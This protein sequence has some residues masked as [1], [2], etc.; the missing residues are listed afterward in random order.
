MQSDTEPSHTPFTTE[1]YLEHL[2]LRTDH[3]LP[4]LSAWDHLP[5]PQPTNPRRQTNSPLFRIAAKDPPRASALCTYITVYVKPSA[6][7]PP[8]PRMCLDCVSPPGELARPPASLQRVPPSSS[9]P[10]LSTPQQHPPPPL[11]AILADAS[12]SVFLVE[13]G[14]L[15]RPWGPRWPQVTARR[16]HLCFPDEPSS[17]RRYSVGIFLCQRCPRPAAP[18]VHHEQH[19]DAEHTFVAN[20]PTAKTGGR[21]SRLHHYNCST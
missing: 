8:Q 7:L 3:T 12:A 10:A 1:Q 19:P 16:A 17:Y 15:C 13:Y 6:S 20:W 14:L 5:E 4:R 21:A 11:T 18:P 9:P 2:R